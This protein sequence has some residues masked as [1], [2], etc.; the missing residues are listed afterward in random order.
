M[1]DLTSGWNQFG[2][3]Y[4]FPII[5]GRVKVLNSSQVGPVSVEEAASRNWIRRTIYW[6]DVGRGE[7]AYS[8]SPFTEIRPWMGYWIKAL[9]ASS[10]AAMAAIAAAGPVFDGWKLDLK[11]RSGASGTTAV[12]GLDS[13]ASDGYSAEDVERPPSLANYVALAFPHQ[14]WGANSGGYIQDIRR[15]GGDKVWEME[16]LTDKKDADVVLTWPGISSVPKTYSLKLEDLETGARKDMRTTSSYRYNTGSSSVRRFRITAESAGR[17][18]L[19]ITGLTVKPSRA[20]GTATVSYS[21]STD[22][23]SDVRIRSASGATVANLASGSRVTRGISSIAWN[24]RNQ[25]GEPVPVGSYIVEVVATT[26]EGEVAK[27][28]MPFIVA[29]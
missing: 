19:L 5:W 25:R 23:V 15:S 6:Y 7:Y 1:I 18:R 13:R 2:N 11:A 4:L 22:A 12:I 9:T 27:A 17:G 10:R 14:D 24:Y 29:R 20:T 8:S 3:P 26:P 16:V 21:L 28:V